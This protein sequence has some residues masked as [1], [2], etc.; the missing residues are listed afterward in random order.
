M[1]VDPGHKLE[2][3]AVYESKN[4]S[5]KKLKETYFPHS[6][7]SHKTI[8]YWVQ[9]ENWQKDHFADVREAIDQL[10][11]AQLPTDEAKEIIKGKLLQEETKLNDKDLDEYGKVVAT[12]L[13]YN[14][15]A[16]KNLQLLMGENILKSKKIADASSHMTTKAAYHTMLVNTTK[17]LHGEKHFISPYDPKNDDLK[18]Y[19]DEEMDAM[20][21]DQ[22][23]GMLK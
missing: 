19:T 16:S 1:A 4:I 20:N 9:K 3:R 11:D 14:V 6:E 7:V 15:L 22:L 10:V 21:D 5:P 12:E 13:C 2:I 17:V 8:E 18:V 23:L